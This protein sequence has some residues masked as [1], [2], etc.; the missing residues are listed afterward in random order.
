MGVLTVRQTIATVIPNGTSSSVPSGTFASAPN[1]GNLLYAILNTYPTTMVAASGWTQDVA[2]DSGGSHCAAFY[3]YAGAS[4]SATQSPITTTEQIWEMVMFE[5]SGV[6][7]V[8]A[9]DHI[10]S[11]GSVTP[12]VPTSGGTNTTTTGTANQLI[13]TGIVGGPSNSTTGTGSFTQSTTLAQTSVV[14]GNFN[15]A[16]N[17]LAGSLFVASSGTTLN[18]TWSW[19][20]AGYFSG[21]STQLQSAAS[22]PAYGQMLLCNI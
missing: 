2:Y 12:G 6:A 10:A 16:S 17:A 11:Q 15:Y 1:N 8:W 13:L 3:K 7:G 22:N 18:D 9:T 14:G 4:E 19:S 5:V 20:V 21:I